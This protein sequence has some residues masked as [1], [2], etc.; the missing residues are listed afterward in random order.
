M[1]D[2]RSRIIGAAL[3]LVNSGGVEAVTT[4]SVAASARVQPPAIYRA[5][6]NMRGLL[7]AVAVHGFAEYLRDKPAPAEGTDSVDVLRAGW[8]MNVQFG[9]LHPELYRLMYGSAGAGAVNE[10]AGNAFE[11]LL[12]ITREIARTGRLA[13]DSNTA[14]DMMHSGAMGV[15]FTLLNTPSERR[16]DDLSGRMRELIISA[17]CDRDPIPDPGPPRHLASALNEH[18]RDG[19]TSLSFGERALLGEL[20]TRLARTTAGEGQH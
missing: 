7:D 1:K 3:D 18:L 8:D 14:A 6:H 15:T 13:V 17:I 4:R 11:K 16:D 12:T 5:F 19:P 10:A 20:L 2:P 9:L